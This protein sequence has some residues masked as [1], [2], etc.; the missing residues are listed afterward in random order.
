ML[1]ATAK[2][3]SLD[4]TTG[5]VRTEGNTVFKQTWAKMSAKYFFFINISSNK[6]LGIILSI[7]VLSFLWITNDTFIFPFSIF[8]GN[9]YA[10]KEYFLYLFLALLVVHVFS[11]F[12]QFHTDLATPEVFLTLSWVLLCHWM[13]GKLQF[14]CQLKP[15]LP[16]WRLETTD[17]LGDLPSKM[18]NSRTVFPVFW[19][20]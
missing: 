14:F 18:C 3:E 13:W 2:T 7:N 20:L 1:W 16:N 11:V 8:I 9:M 4:T 12:K 10:L 5:L 17:V 15:Y 19:L 6:E